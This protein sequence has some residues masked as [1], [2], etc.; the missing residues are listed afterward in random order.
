MA[1]KNIHA[2]TKLN[3]T[4][5]VVVATFNG[6]KFIKEQLDSMLGQTL[7]PDLIL[8]VDDCST[9]NTPE[10]IQK[11]TE[12]H[13]N[14]R[15]YQNEQNLGWIKN[16]EKGISLCDTDYI[17]L[18][19]QDDIWFPEKIE[20]CYRAMTSADN[21]GLCLYNV[22]LI[23]EDGERIGK[24]LWEWSNKNYIMSKL[25]AQQI[26]AETRTPNIGNGHFFFNSELKKHL[27]PFPGENHCGH[28]WWVCA[29][30]FFLYNPIYIASPLSYYRLHP[31]QASGAGALLLEYKGYKLKKKIFD[32]ER[33]IRSVKREIHKL[34]NRRKI[35]EERKRDKNN[36]SK[37]FAAAIERL[38]NIIEINKSEHESEDKEFL[39][40][41]LQ[42][43]RK[44]LLSEK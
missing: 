35:V 27:L 34:F 30:A 4:I 38:I 23:H 43:G 3:H 19:D 26:L 36:R 24:T 6:K 9:D 20:K 15:F 8:I 21:V 44:Q 2:K 29:V 42:T 22:E 32:H 31:D 33:I 18:S 7:K 17:V 40:N 14:I 37:E 25:E 16:F 1:L 41:M 5:G 12:H 13:Q 39:I 28:D 10:I 11:Y